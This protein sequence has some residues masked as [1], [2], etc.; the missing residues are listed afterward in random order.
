MRGFT[1]RR[2]LTGCSPRCGFK[3]GKPVRPIDGN[4]QFLDV[5]QLCAVCLMDYGMYMS[6]VLAI[7]FYFITDFMLRCF[8][9]VAYKD[10]QVMSRHR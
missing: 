2:G 6:K 8:F 4:E 7:I 9:I 10:K 3:P 5:E 1:L